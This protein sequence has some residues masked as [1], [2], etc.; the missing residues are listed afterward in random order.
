MQHDPHFYPSPSRRMATY[1]DRGMVATSQPLGAQAGM[2]ILQR[3][4]NAVDAAIATAAA[5]TVV[6]PTS[7]GLGSDAFAIVW[8]DGE[9]HGLNASGPAPQAAT[10]EAVRALGHE[11]M[12]EHGL[13]PVTVPGAPAAWAALSERF[14]KLPFAELLAPAIALAE[15]GFPISPVVNRMWEE[16]YDSYR[17]HDDAAFE[18]WFDT[19][20]PHGRAPHVGERWAAPDHA[21]TLRA[22]GET[23]AK[24]FYEGELAERIDAFFREHGGLLRRED[25]AAFQPEWV[26]PIGTRFRGH[27]IW[28]IPPNGSG[29]IALQALGM[30][31]RL[32]EEGRDPVETLHRRIEA[33]KL[34]YVDGLR[35]VTER[36]A[37]GPSVAQLLTDDYLEARAGLIGEQALDPQHGNP[38]HGGTVYLA[39]A[40]GEGNMVSFIQSNF[41]GFGSGIVVPGTGISLQNRGWSFSLDSAHANALAPGKRTYHTII[42]GFIT[43]DGEAVGPFGVMGGFMQPQGHVQVVAAMLDDHLNPQAALDLPRWKWTQG[44]TVEVEPHFP[45][46]LAQALARRGHQVV[47]RTDS[48]SFGRGQVILRDRDSGVL[49]GGTEPRTDGAVL[50]W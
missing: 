25:L 47:K 38:I 31:E 18:P 17:Q 16:A 3:G 15:A 41:K 14:G 26:E 36:D 24:A 35:Y 32:G 40:D 6:E 13:L 37:M 4:G 39:T 44:R 21:R 46:H 1:G 12:P 30:L 23:R 49:C 22:I 2:Q 8:I 7:N 29:L 48:L 50:A 27:D 45:D 19:F 42:P 28:E 33:T 5:L 34:G 20:A 11:R 10:L 9:L 43:R